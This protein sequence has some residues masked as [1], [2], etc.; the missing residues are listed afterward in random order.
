MFQNKFNRF[1]YVW[2]VRLLYSFSRW[3]LSNNDL[4]FSRVLTSILSRN[5]FNSH[6][7][8]PVRF[9]ICIYLLS[10][11]SVLCYYWK[12]A[13]IVLFNLNLFDVCRAVMCKTSTGTN[14]VFT[15]W[16][17]TRIKFWSLQLRN[18][19]RHLFAPTHSVPILTF[20]L[21]FIWTTILLAAMLV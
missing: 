5:S 6:W 20:V 15:M 10:Y 18:S 8:D 7:Y 17:F 11:I 3:H 14:I 19:L 9:E 4:K 1:S 16:V 2:C 12:W 13:R 21:R